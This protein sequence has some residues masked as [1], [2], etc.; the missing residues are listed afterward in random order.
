MVKDEASIVMHRVQ[1]DLAT[2]AVLTQFAV[3]SV[4]SKKA[5]DQ[6]KKLIKR[7]TDDGKT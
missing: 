6:F 3:S 1:S 7:M 2:E 5:G 4:L